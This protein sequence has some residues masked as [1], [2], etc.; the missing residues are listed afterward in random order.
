ALTGRRRTGIRR[1]IPTPRRGILL[2]ILCVQAFLSLR[3]SN[4]AFEDEALYLY[5]GH[6]ELAH[7][8]YHQQIDNFAAY[9]SG[10]PVLYPIVGA[11][12][13][14][15]GGVFAARLLSLAFM[16]G[17]TSL[18]YLTG[19]RLFGVRSALCGAGLFG[20]TASAIF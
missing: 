14:Q 12:M 4:T 7:L 19:R 20:T 8:L 11:I 17:A 2:G 16:L 9:F 6:L 18:V 15:I 3:N 1:L 10:A 5:S 13:D